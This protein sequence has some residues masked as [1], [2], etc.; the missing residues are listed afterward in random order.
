MLFGPYFLF[1]SGNLMA[2][3]WGIAAH[4]AHMFSWYKYLSFILVF[5]NL[6]V[7][8]VGISF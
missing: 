2:T 3:Y 8:G 7:F 6:S 5:S 4:S 1:G